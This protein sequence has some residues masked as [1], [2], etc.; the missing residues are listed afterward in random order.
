VSVVAVAGEKSNWW[1]E[2][3]NGMRLE[4]VSGQSG[5]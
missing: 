3:E 2:V 1:H 4:R 5:L